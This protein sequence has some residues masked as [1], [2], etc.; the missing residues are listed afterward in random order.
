[1][2]KSAKDL[3]FDK[4]RAKYRQAVRQAQLESKSKD[5]KIQQLED[6]VRILEAQKKEHEDWI[7]RLLTYTEM[8][9]EDM[10]TVIQ[11]E[12]EVAKA[13]GHL[14]TLFSFGGTSSNF[15]M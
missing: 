8:S 3:A 14:N 5:A 6:R 12:K 9:H 7:E 4:E 15:R 10:I 1:M 11:K 13:M 2:E